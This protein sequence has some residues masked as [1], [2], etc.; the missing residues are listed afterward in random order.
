[1]NAMKRTF[2]LFLSFWCIVLSCCNEGTNISG[3][4]KYISLDVEKTFCDFTTEEKESF[5]E[6]Q[7]RFG[8]Y[9]NF[10]NGEYILKKNCTPETLGISSALFEYFYSIMIHTNENLRELPVYK[11][12]DGELI[13][14][15]YDESLFPRLKTKTESGDDFYDDVLRNPGGVHGGGSGSSS[16]GS[17]SGSGGGGGTSGAIGGVTK[18][19]IHWYGYDIYLSNYA[20]HEIAMG[21]TV[22]SVLSVA[23]PETTISKIITVISGLCAV[24][25]NELEYRYPNG[26]IL[27]VTSPVVVGTCIPYSLSEQ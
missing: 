24:A 2:Y 17:G 19:I 1:M 9:V 26:V 7:N 15:I 27:K 12:L 11:S 20:L 3:G 21:A 22:V 13:L 18:V 16:G 5:F 8:Q 25:A 14:G 23:I 6:A 4:L 10:E